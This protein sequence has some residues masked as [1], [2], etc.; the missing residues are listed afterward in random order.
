MTV[1]LQ[2]GG[3]DADKEVDNDDDDDEYVMKRADDKLESSLLSSDIEFYIPAQ[4][5]SPSPFDDDTTRAS[6]GDGASTKNARRSDHRA[7][8]DAATNTLVPL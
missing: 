7:V 1:I 3:A 6:V 4:S 5:R 8:D 2:L